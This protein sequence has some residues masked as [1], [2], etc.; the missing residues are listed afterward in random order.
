MR[1]RAGLSRWHRIALV[2]ELSSA[3]MMDGASALGARY[4]RAQRQSAVELQQQSMAKAQAIFAAQVIFPFTEGLNF[5]EYSISGVFV[6]SVA[7][8]TYLR[9]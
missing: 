4:A 7:S 2:R 5:K 3:A 9:G 8:C 1:W 6:M